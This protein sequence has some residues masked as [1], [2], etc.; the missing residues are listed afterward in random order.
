L[1][2]LYLAKMKELVQLKSADY[3]FL[4][5]LASAALG[6]KSKKGDGQ[7]EL[8]DG[9]GLDEMTPEQEA[10]L[11]QALGDDFDKLYGGTTN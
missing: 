2:D 3:K 10:E 1:E 6:G 11:R 5:E 8:D 9:E 7:Y 4:I